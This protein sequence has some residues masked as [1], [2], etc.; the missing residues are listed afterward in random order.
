[1]L[2]LICDVSKEEQVKAIIEKI[3]AEFGKFDIAYNN[4][5]I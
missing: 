4:V 3:V 2:T 5:E 1:V